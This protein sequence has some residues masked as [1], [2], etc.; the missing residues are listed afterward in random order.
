MIYRLTLILLV[1]GSFTF[2]AV[3]AD[4]Q[5]ATNEQ[6]T[7]VLLAQYPFWIVA[8]AVGVVWVGWKWWQHRSK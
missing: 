2:F 3:V 8:I 4:T 6:I 5:H 7:R 1:L